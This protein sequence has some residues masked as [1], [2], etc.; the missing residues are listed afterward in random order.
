MVTTTFPQKVASAN[1]V[2]VAYRQESTY[3]TAAVGKYRKARF[4]DESIEPLKETGESNEISDDRAPGESVVTKQGGG[5]AINGEFSVHTFDDFIQ[6]SFY[7][8][9]F[10]QANFGENVTSALISF[11]TNSGNQRLVGPAG[12]ADYWSSTVGLASNDV[13]QVRGSE[14]PS[15]DG[16]YVVVSTVPA[17][18]PDPMVVSRIYTTFT[19]TVQA[20]GE[21]VQVVKVGTL[22]LSTITV[23]PDGGDATLA[24]F[25]DS[26]ANA[27]FANAAV[28]DLVKLSRNTGTTANDVLARITV[29]TDDDTVQVRRFDG[30]NFAADSTASYVID[31]GA[32]VSNGTTGSS[33]TI[34]K[35]NTDLTNTFKRGTGQIPDTMDLS[36]SPDGQV[37]VGF[38]FK[39]KVV[40]TKA[41]TAATGLMEAASNNVTSG[42]RNCTA[43]I[44]A[45]AEFILRT[46]SVRIANNLRENDALGQVGPIA[47]T[48]GEFSVTGEINSYKTGTANGLIAEGHLDTSLGFIIEDDNGLAAA[49][50]APRVKFDSAQSPTTGKNSDVVERIPWRAGKPASAAV[51][52]YVTWI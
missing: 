48:E 11:D 52:T 36:M 17:T 34:E 40:E 23:T 50:L 25:N 16:T 8:S 31:F 12:S 18:D 24:V 4:A 20:A 2:R 29:V 41:A 7:S 35:Q 44:Q 51:L 38:G 13:I 19:P 6:G 43:V 49:M 5:G 47:V 42:S 15:L 33:W 26:G 9:G 32:E 22:V 21:E 10:A 37:T 14:D 28:G 30:S 39:G 27:A 3:G 45:G 46:F 1:R